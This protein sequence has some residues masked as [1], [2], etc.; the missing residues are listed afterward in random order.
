MLNKHKHLGVFYA[1]LAAVCNSTIGIA[2]EFGFSGARYDTIAL[3]KTLVGLVVCLVV[4]LILKINIR[5]SRKRLGSAAI[6]S[7]FGIFLLYFFETL[8]FSVAPVSLVSFSIYASGVISILLGVFFLKESL[9]LRKI[10]SFSL[11]F[12]G[13]FL[14]SNAEYAFNIG[15][16]CAVVAGSGYSIYLFLIKVLNEEVGFDFLVLL[17]IFGSMYLAVPYLFNGVEVPSSDAWPGILWLA[18]V[19]TIFGFYFTNKALS[20]AEVGLVQ[21]VETSDPMFASM[22]AFLFF[23]QVISVQGYFGCFAIFVS[24]IILALPNNKKG[25]MG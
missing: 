9:N 21:V 10:L 16:I 20:S 22:F 19:P 2:N 23:G 15:L 7:F 11:V 1:L 17:F 4:C 5:I 13:I 24:L 12:F 14:I 18:V 8:A 25:A 6:L 3:Y